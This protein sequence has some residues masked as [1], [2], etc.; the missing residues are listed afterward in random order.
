MMEYAQKAKDL[1]HA[2][3]VVTDHD[4]M[5]KREH[6]SMRF[7][8]EGQDFVLKREQFIQQIMEAREVERV[9]GIP[10]IVGIEI[11]MFDGIEGLLF[12]MEACCAW[13]G[14]AKAVHEG[15][16][17]AFDEFLKEYKDKC[18]L[19]MCHPNVRWMR[20]TDEFYRRVFDGYEVGNCCAMW[21]DEDIAR[22]REIMPEGGEF[23]NYDAHCISDFGGERC[24]EIDECI[25][26]DEE[27]VKWIKSMWGAKNKN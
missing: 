13:W 5:L 9:V 17:L 20:H 24:N 18:A 15:D 26:N 4:Y 12:G 2:C 10:V 19:I 3:L 6:L 14:Y 8:S 7:L 27:L 21:S 11:S 1:G 25:G 16:L 22:L 23:V